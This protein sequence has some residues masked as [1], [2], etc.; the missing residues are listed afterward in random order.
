M[1]SIRDFEHRIGKPIHRKEGPPVMEVSWR[2][3]LHT[4]FVYMNPWRLVVFGF[5]PDGENHDG[6]GWW[7]QINGKKIREEG[8]DTPRK[9]ALALRRKLGEIGREIASVMKTKD[10]VPDE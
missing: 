2:L 3:R 8:Y 9:A 10:L 4:E 5:S 6:R 1:F 7:A